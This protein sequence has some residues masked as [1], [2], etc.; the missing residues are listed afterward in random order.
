VSSGR[1]GGN[2]RNEIFGAWCAPRT[3]RSRLCAVASRRSAATRS[4]ARSP[5]AMCHTPSRPDSV[6]YGVIVPGE[7]NGKTYTPQV[8]RTRFVGQA[9][10][11]WD[12]PGAVPVASAP[13]R[14]GSN[15]RVVRH[16]P[17]PFER[18]TQ[19]SSDL[20]D[21]AVTV[22]VLESWPQL[23]AE[24]RKRISQGRS[25]LE[26]L[27]LESKRPDPEGAQARAWVQETR[28]RERC[29]ETNRGQGLGG[30]VPHDPTTP[31]CSASGML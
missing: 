16:R 3:P 27:D 31:G 5:R 24:A 7:P 1:K 13:A 15:G 29:A 9:S 10:I 30:R 26:E 20:V 19:S 12:L 21:S 17:R 8:R 4:A 11:F 22:G 28:K 25:A 6:R 2:A 18:T 14:L 23:P